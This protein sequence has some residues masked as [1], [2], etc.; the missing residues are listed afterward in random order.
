MG[1]RQYNTQVS[2]LSL[3]MVCGLL[4]SVIFLHFILLSFC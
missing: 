4:G 2:V 3:L 1:G